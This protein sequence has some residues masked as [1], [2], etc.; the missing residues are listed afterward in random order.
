MALPQSARPHNRGSSVLRQQ[1]ALTSPPA[2][3]HQDK[4]NEG[5]QETS[6]DRKASTE[7]GGALLPSC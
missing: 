6:S 5:A 7:T 1:A 4:E 3:G 2:K